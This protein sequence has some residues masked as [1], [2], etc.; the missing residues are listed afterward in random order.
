MIR[1]SI[2]AA[3]V[4]AIVAFLAW[5]YP[6]FAVPLFLGLAAALDVFR[7]DLKLLRSTEKKLG[8]GIDELESDNAAVNRVALFKERMRKFSE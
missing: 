8:G 6:A 2:K 7:E 1:T 5:R 3:A 4:F